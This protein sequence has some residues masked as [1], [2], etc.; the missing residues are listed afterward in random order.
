MSQGK[1]V[2]PQALPTIAPLAKV[3]GAFAPRQSLALAP[4]DK[5]RL[6]TTKYPLRN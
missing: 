5:H 2:Y 6:A 3:A 4:H 1:A